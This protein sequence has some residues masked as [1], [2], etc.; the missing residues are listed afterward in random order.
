MTTD[1]TDIFYKI[2]SNEKDYYDFNLVTNKQKKLSI[3]PILLDNNLSLTDTASIN[4]KLVNIKTLMLDSEYFPINVQN[5]GY[6]ESDTIIDESISSNKSKNI[7]SEITSIE[8]IFTESDKSTKIPINKESEIY[9]ES[10]LSC[11]Y[12][13][14]NSSETTITNKSEQSSSTYWR[15]VAKVNDT[16]NKE[17]GIKDRLT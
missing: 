9:S 15:Y 4:K 5:G 10:S 13:E 2:D 6:T 17:F 12:S 3:D 14:R 7:E 11:I 1:S 8:S 16:F